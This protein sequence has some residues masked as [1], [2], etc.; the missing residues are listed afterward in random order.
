MLGSQLLILDCVLCLG[1]FWFSNYFPLDSPHSN[2]TAVVSSSSSVWSGFSHRFSSGT[3][4][5]VAWC[6]LLE[7]PTA[8]SP[9]PSFPLSGLLSRTRTVSG[10]CSERRSRSLHCHCFPWAVSW[11]SWWAFL[12][13][14]TSG[15]LSLPEWCAKSSSCKS[16]TQ[17]RFSLPPWE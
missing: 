15:R 5:C 6:F 3:S 11:P 8:P 13:A 2:S 9:R 1:R 7:E 14:E 12:S 16:E 17:S 10:T 4:E